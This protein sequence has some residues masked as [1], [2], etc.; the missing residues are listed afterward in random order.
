MIFAVRTWNGAFS[1]RVAK[2]SDRFVAQT[3]RVY[4]RAEYMAVDRESRIVHG[5]RHTFACAGHP[6]SPANPYRHQEGR[7]RWDALESTMGPDHR[8]GAAARN[9]FFAGSAG[10]PSILPAILR[11]ARNRQTHILRLL[12]PGTCGC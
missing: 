12:L 2:M 9:A 6:I 7:T 3:E 10:R 11:D 8:E 4:P 1:R 5:N